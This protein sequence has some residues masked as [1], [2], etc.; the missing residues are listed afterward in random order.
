[1]SSNNSYRKGDI[2]YCEFPLIRRDKTGQTSLDESK[3]EAGKDKSQKSKDRTALIVIDRG[4]QCVV[5]SITKSGHRE[6]A[7]AIT[8]KDCNERDSLSFD[9]SYAKPTTLYTIGKNKIRRKS[10]SLKEEKLKEITDA[11]ENA[12]KEPIIEE[13]VPKAI[14]RPRRIR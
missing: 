7:I 13:E 14:A 11:I 1:M 5:C 4:N 3:D 6:D 8:L 2:I 12:L 9:P 10:G